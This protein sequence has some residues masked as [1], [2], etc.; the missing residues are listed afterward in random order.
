ML[1]FSD[2]FEVE[3]A[4]KEDDSQRAERVI[5]WISARVNKRATKWV[6]YIEK[7]GEDNL[8]DVRTPWWDELRRCAEGNVIPSRTESWN[9]PVA[10]MIEF[11]FIM[12]YE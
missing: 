6:E 2:L 7:I 11:P 4:C 9:H 3:N 10:G 5:D 1:R 8:K 12:P